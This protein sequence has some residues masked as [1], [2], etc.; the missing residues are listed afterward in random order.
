MEL[1]YLSYD[2][3]MAL[4]QRPDAVEIFKWYASYGRDFLHAALL[5][6]G[7]DEAL[8]AEARE[9]LSKFREQEKCN[10]QKILASFRKYDSCD[11]LQ[12]EGPLHGNVQLKILQSFSKEDAYEILKIYGKYCTLS[13]KIQAELLNVLSKQEAKELLLTGLQL[14][15]DAFKK[16]VNL[17]DQLE[18]LEFLWNL[19]QKGCLS[20]KA[21]F[22]AMKFLPATSVK[23]ILTK[24]I[25][26][27]HCLSA[28]TM[29]QIFKVFS[30]EDAKTIF[31]TCI[32]RQVITGESKALLNIVSSLPKKHACELI[33]YAV[34][35][36][37]R[38][39]FLNLHDKTFLNK[40]FW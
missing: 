33:R 10:Q 29:Q 1:Q 26:S 12:Q 21:M 13:Y 23:A 22:N 14:T 19:Y 16:L 6:F 8:C 34:D 4:F 3:Q 32:D 18:L 30:L 7:P 35:H 5:D 25:D 11:I 24:H 20:D 9:K 27:C 37:R 2:K 31:K 17:C 36:Q 39:P 15:D 38:S 28:E 40:W